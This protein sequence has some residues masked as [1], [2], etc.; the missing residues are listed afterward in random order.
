MSKYSIMAFRTSGQ[1]LNDIAE[2]QP[3]DG[4]W[5]ALEELLSE[6]W[7]VG[8]SPDALP[9]LFQVFERFPQEDGAGV[10]WSI[11]HGVEALDISYETQLRLSIA[12]QPS[13]MG[14]VMLGRLEKNAS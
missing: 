11:V 7:Q 8:V 6:L 14:K 12:R 2:F 5:L 1:I 10:L 4:N 3:S 9:V 13:F